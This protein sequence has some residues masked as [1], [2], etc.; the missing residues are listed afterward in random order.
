MTM[1]RAASSSRRQGGV[2]PS[3][4]ATTVWQLLFTVSLLASRSDTVLVVFA[5]SRNSHSDAVVFSSSASSPQQLRALQHQ[6]QAAAATRSSSSSSPVPDGSFM[7]TLQEFLFKVQSTKEQQTAATA[8]SNSNGSQVCEDTKRDVCGTSTR[9]TSGVGGSTGGAG[10]IDSSNKEFLQ[11]QLIS[12]R[13]VASPETAAAATTTTMDSRTVLLKEHNFPDYPLTYAALNSLFTTDTKVLVHE[14][15]VQLFDSLVAVFPRPD[16][17]AVIGAIVDSSRP[18][19][20]GSVVLDLRSCSSGSTETRTTEADVEYFLGPYSRPSKLSTS[21]VDVTTVLILPY[22]VQVLQTI[23]AHFF[24]AIIRITD[25]N[26][27][28]QI[29]GVLDGTTTVSSS[30]QLKSMNVQQVKS[31]V[32]V[33]EAEFQGTLDSVISTLHNMRTDGG[34]NFTSQEGALQELKCQLQVIL[35]TRTSHLEQVVQKS[36]S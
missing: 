6:R 18:R 11:R 29:L 21:L 31:F 24:P 13:A 32:R 23:H 5:Y 16:M 8:G 20:V 35:C 19:S 3:A 4:L 22:T 33:V 36:T 7:A 25:V 17:E 10:S 15:V 34:R 27:L 26:G 9:T 28:A 30:S 2:L 12:G 14:V 1:M